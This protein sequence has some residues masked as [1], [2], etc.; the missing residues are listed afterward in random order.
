M[1]FTK[2][3][4]VVHHYQI[5]EPDQVRRFYYCIVNEFQFKFPELSFTV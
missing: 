2:A 3:L 1:M 4:N 5:L